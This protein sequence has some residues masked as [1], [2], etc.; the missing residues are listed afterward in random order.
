MRSS[1]PCVFLLLTAMAIPSGAVTSDEFFTKAMSTGYAKDILTGDVADQ[2][3]AATHSVEPTLA[4]L[5]KK[6]T[7][8]DGCTV[9]HFT[10][11]LP[12]VPLKGGGFAGEYVTVSRLT[13]CKDNIDTTRAEVLECHVGKVD[14][15]PAR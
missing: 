14:C 15:M 8:P 1:T 9:F 10:V 5:E 7:S 4:I 3:R 12:K 11:T 2:L 13:A 6:G